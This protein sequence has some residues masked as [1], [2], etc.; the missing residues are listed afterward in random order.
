VYLPEDVLLSE[1]LKMVRRTIRKWVDEEILPLEQEVDERD[2]LWPELRERLLKRSKELGVWALSVPTEYGGQGMNVLG[3]CVAAEAIGRASVPFWFFVDGGKPYLDLKFA[4]PYQL[5]KFFLPQIRGEKFQ[6]FC[7]TEPDAGSDTTAIKTYA[8]KKGNVWSINGMKSFASDGDIAGYLIV[9]ARTDRQT[10]AKKGTTIFLVER[11]TPGIQL[12]RVQRKMGHKGRNQVEFAFDDCRVPE[13]NVYWK[14]NDGYRIALGTLGHL[15][16]VYA[17]RVLGQIER[18][19]ELSVDYAKRRVTFGK[20][21]AARQAIQWMLVDMAVELFA[22]RAIVYGTAREIDKGLAD[23]VKESMTK[24]YVTEAVCRA[25][26]NAVQVFGGIGLMKDVPI[27]RLY[28]DARFFRIPEGTSE[29]HKI[30]IARALLR[31]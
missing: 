1:E 7:L 18:M 21:I 30:V 12:I 3:E 19:L 13:E 20:P 22:G 8:V 17:A 26:D 9:V 10:E 11:E 28:R 2:E 15:R 14:V 16:L 25:A 29:M 27:E 31:D 5:D 23:P 24:L 4:T 6:C